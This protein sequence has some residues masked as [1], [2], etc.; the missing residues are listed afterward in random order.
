[1]QIKVRGG[2]SFYGLSGYRIGSSLSAHRKA[3]NWDMNKEQKNKR[4]GTYRKN[5]IA[6]IGGEEDGQEV[7]CGAA[8]VE[9]LCSLG[10]W[11]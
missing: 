8:Q 3:I 4:D 1:M 6:L 9:S 10:E 7:A 5:A 11:G 2:T